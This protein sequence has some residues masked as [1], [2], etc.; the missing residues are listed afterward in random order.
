LVVAVRASLEHCFVEFD[1]AF[2]LN[3]HHLWQCNKCGRYFANRNQSHACGADTLLINVQR[4]Y[5][6]NFRHGITFGLCFA[7]LN[8][9]RGISP[10]FFLFGHPLKK[11][12]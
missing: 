3:W 4:H 11:R 1:W 8:D 12:L 10:L 7:S 5:R 9:P 2:K 6:V